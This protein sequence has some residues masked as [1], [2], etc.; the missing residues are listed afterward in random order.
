[1]IITREFKL[2]NIK[3]GNYIS[4]IGF[5]DEM[6]FYESEYTLFDV[7]TDFCTIDS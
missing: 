7:S 2:C 1:M 6:P 5:I 4:P 3:R